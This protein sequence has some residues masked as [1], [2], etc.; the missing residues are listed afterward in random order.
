ML[1]TVNVELTQISCGCCGGVYALNERFRQEA[2]EKGKIA[3]WHCPYCQASWGYGES[4]AHKLKKQL[5]QERA[6][7][8]QT[9][10]DLSQT[11]SDL[12]T[13][14]AC[15]R[16]EKGAKT[17]LKKRIAA[18]LCPCCRRPFENLLNHMKTEHPEY[19]NEES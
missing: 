15:R 6:R 10:A 16:S 12:Q 4:E 18:G 5:V 11:R 2:F 1:I 7:H 13:T 9:S 17:K 3:A 19:A 8:D 14:E